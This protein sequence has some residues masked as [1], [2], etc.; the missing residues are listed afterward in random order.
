MLLCLL[1]TGLAGVQRRAAQRKFAA[2]AAAGKYCKLKSAATVVSTLTAI[3][4][5]GKKLGLAV[6]VVKPGVS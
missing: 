4:A 2:A 3:E 5:R 6:L 1:N